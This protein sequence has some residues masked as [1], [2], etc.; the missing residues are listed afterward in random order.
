M[1]HF[2]FPAV[3]LAVL[4]GLKIFVSP[5]FAPNHFWIG[6]AFGCVAGFF[7][8]IGWMGYAFPKM[9]LK[10]SPLPGAILLGL[11]WAVW[12]LPVVDYLGT[13]TPHGT[14]WLPYF[15]AF[16]TAMTA[17]RVLISWMY[18]H[19]KSVL[20]TQLL[21]ASSTSSLVIFSPGHATAAQETLW[22]A[23]YAGAL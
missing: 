20:L 15:L 17:M 2:S 4:F 23:I 13:A 19:T 5:V 14:Y 1:R 6:V 12:H 16:A 22:Y 3:I 7:E 9:Q 11:L 8:E 21:H 18:V 10:R